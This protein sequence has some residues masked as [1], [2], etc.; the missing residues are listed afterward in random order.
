MR[1]LFLDI[2]GCLHPYPPRDGLEQLCWLP[3]L[4][5][6]LEG[7]DDVKVVVHSSW[8]LDMPLHFL[9]HLLAPLGDRFV[10]VTEGEQRFGSIQ[11][12]LHEH[13]HQVSS[14]CI[15]DDMPD[16]FDPVPPQLVVC[17]GCDGITSRRAQKKLR[18]WLRSTESSS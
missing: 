4:V 3:V 8:R 18:H 9:R 2:D 17:P 6:L 11:T 5:R 13:R 1:V 14:F 16:E 7:Q 12:W 10:G 15:V